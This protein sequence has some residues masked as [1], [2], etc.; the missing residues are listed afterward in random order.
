MRNILCS[1]TP[2][3]RPKTTSNVFLVGNRPG[4]SGVYDWP[5]S[6]EPEMLLLQ[7][8]SFSELDLI[9]DADPGPTGNKVCA[10]GVCAVVYWRISGHLTSRFLL[11]AMLMPGRSIDGEG[12]SV[13]TSQSFRVRIITSHQGRRPRFIKRQTRL[14]IHCG[15]AD[16]GSQHHREPPRGLSPGG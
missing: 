1:K 6:Q 7:R 9:S 14:K 8:L 4:A 11:S 16:N 15:A 10:K 12:D 5:L 13:F 2:L 3:K